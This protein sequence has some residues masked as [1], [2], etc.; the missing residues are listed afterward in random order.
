MDRY[1]PNFYYFLFQSLKHT[2]TDFSA[3]ADQDYF[4]VI[5]MSM[6]LSA[7][8]QSGLEIPVELINDPIFENNEVFQGKLTIIR[9]ERV[10]LSPGT[11]DATIINDDG[12]YTC[13][14]LLVAYF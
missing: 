2:H 14:I 8:M 3:V 9:G 4:S 12:M 13:I 7:G 10:S 1:A 6:I 5:D 11:V